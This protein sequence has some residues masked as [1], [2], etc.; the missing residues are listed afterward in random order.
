MIHPF[1]PGTLSRLRIAILERGEQNPRGGTLYSAYGTY[2]HTS[3]RLSRDIP[4]PPSPAPS[5]PF[6]PLLTSQC[7]EAAHHFC[8]LI[9]TVERTKNSPPLKGVKK[10]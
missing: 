6:G 3:E 1:H 5:K 9:H 2:T 4:P 7:A 10:D 8:K